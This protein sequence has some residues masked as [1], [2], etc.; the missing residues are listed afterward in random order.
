MST[1]AVRVI[2]A[3]ARRS[4]LVYNLCFPFVLFA[5]LPGFLRRMLRRGRYRENF[6]QRLGLYS[7][8]NRMRIEGREWIW[9]H[10]ISVGE[11]LVALKLARE[12]H[13]L[14][15]NSNLLISVTTTTG[16]QIAREAAGEWLEVIYNPID[17]APM[18]RRALEVIRPVTVLFIEGEVWPNLVSECVRRGI[19][20]ALINA[21]LS[22]RSEGRF[23]R[24]RNW[25]GAIFRLL[26]LICVVEPADER[27]WNGLGVPA[28]KLRCTGSIKFDD[29]APQ[30]SRAEEFR[31]LIAP[32][33]FQPET[34]VL[35]AGST[36]DGEEE[37]LARTLVTLRA[38]FP[39]LRLILV[40]RHVERTTGIAAAL[41]Q[42][43]LNVVR[44]TTLPRGS[45]VRGDIL[46]VDTTGELRDWY[47]LATVVFIGKTLN[48]IGG[49]NPAEPALIGK[50]V[51]FG[52]HMENFAALTAH[53]L[54]HDA[55]I[56]VD[57]AAALEV[58][59]RHLLNN[60]K[61]R[62]QLGGY[63]RD[64][65]ASHQGATRR[66]SEVIVN[67]SAAFAP[68]HSREPPKAMR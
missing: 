13:A 10:S 64:A 6:G 48:A 28:G 3:D 15:P 19:F 30:S 4:L 23:R 36:H 65:L 2:P 46:L 60:P 32:L 35:V 49:Q 58:G 7:A 37:I 11:T 38:D 40:P 56:Q 54:S 1:S 51:V 66:V 42:F 12:L 52:P 43:G 57:D 53:L 8:E 45:P 17:F 18:V 44:R 50:P 33:G 26:D 25:T 29:S 55:A 21:R 5:L 27:R 63:A 67:A 59:L 34:P 39:E 14:L 61:R 20:S 62:A 47:Q 16:F 22:P 9:I 24:F 31:G 41:A 68:T